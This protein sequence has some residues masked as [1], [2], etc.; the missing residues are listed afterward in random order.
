M[1]RTVHIMFVMWVKYHYYMDRT[2]HIIFQIWV[3]GHK[4]TPGSRVGV[5]GAELPREQKSKKLIF[6]FHSESHQVSV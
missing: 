3:M 5:W 4:W 1:D 2:V 6:C